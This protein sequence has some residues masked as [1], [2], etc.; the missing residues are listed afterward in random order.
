LFREDEFPEEGGMPGSSLALL[1]SNLLDRHGITRA[2]LTY[3]T[4]L[5]IA[6]LPNPYFAAEI[7]AASNRWTAAEWLPADSR[8]YSSII[9]GNQLPDLA[10]KEIHAYADNA[11]FVQ[12]MMA[13]NGLTKPFGHPTMDPIHRAAA[14]TGRPIAIHSFSAG[15]IA[16]LPSGGAYPNYYIEYH[17]HGCQ[18]VMT[19]LVSF[20]ANGVFEKYPNLRL[21][22]TEGGTAWIPAIVWR[23]RDLYDEGAAEELPWLRSTMHDSLREH[24]MSTTQPLE[25][26][27]R[28]EVLTDMFSDIEGE[29]FFCFATDY[30]HWDA[31]EPLYVSRRVPASWHDSVFY[32]NA[33]RLYGWSAESVEAEARSQ[34]AVGSVV[35]S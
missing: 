11:R 17:A 30:P 20:L 27:T 8:L 3:S 13:N 10:A 18:N 31:D 29:R 9:V 33:C 14:E 7:A 26:P 15:G 4:A 2:V 25:A 35:S 1:A 34:M 28:P 6:N 21:L 12:V 19:H 5:F 23:L 22:L 24:V 32:K 16:P